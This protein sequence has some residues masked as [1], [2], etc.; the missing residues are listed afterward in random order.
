[1]NGIEFGR[2]MR[3]ALGIDPTALPD[4]I[5]GLA[6]QLGAADVVV[7]LVDFSQVT[8]EPMPDRAAHTEIRSSESVASSTAGRSFLA[9]QPIIEPTAGG[10]VRI[11]VPIAEGSNRTGVLAMTVPDASQSVVEGCADLGLFA[12]YLIAVHDRSTDLYNL[13]RRRR[14][15]T[16]S[17]SMQWDLLPPLVVKSPEIE[18]AGLIEPAYDVGGDCFDYSINGATADIALFDP[19]GH[20]IRSAL[21]AGLVMGAYRHQRRAGKTLTEIHET[22]D[23][24]ISDQYDDM[25]F[26]TGQLARLQLSTGTLQWTNAGHPAP[27]LLRDGTV[28]DVLSCPPTMPWGLGRPLSRPARQPPTVAT[29][30]LEPGDEVLFFTDGAIEVRN[31]ERRELGRDDLAVLFSR[32]LSDERQPEQTV[33]HLARAVLEYSQDDLSDDSSFVLLHWTGHA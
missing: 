33:R 15:I 4:L 1:V 29:A 26:V 5:A 12:G 13:H 23:D 30:T 14:S 22:L 28:T 17:A 32:N 11:W 31:R 18:I 27:L 10:G 2:A 24:T 3:A 6:A 16:L 25:S 9:Q 8:L 19:V 20:D 7:Y 21:L